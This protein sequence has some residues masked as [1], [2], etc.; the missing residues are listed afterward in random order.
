M[1]QPEVLDSQI[2]VGAKQVLKALN[3]NM[4]IKVFLA[5]DAEEAVVGQLLEVSKTFDVKVDR[6]HTM[7]ELGVLAAIDVK[8]AAIGLVRKVEH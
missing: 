2:I 8:T 4:L 1:T 7:R 6:N 5:N 3:R